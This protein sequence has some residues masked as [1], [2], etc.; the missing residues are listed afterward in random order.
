MGNHEN[1]F[2]TKT[3]K[4]QGTIYHEGR[5]EIEVKNLFSLPS[6]SSWWSVF[7]F[8]A[9]KNSSAQRLSKFSECVQNWKLKMKEQNCD[10]LKQVSRVSECSAKY[11]CP[12][13]TEQYAGFA[14]TG[15]GRFC[16]GVS[17]LS[18]MFVKTN[19]SC[20]KLLSKVSESGVQNNN[21]K[22]KI[23]NYKNGK[24]ESKN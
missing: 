19:N 9:V 17:R 24:R 23:E 2:T 16:T 10:T 6:C 4:I 13:C 1:K 14:K 11:G 20:A 5:E 12:K 3:Q 15:K 7:L 18:R 22:L 21:W 8:F